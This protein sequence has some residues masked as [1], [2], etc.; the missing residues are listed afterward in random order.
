MKNGILLLALAASA[1]SLHAQKTPEAKLTEVA[2]F[3][4]QQV[5]GVGVSPRTGRAFVN[6][7]YWSDPQGLSVGEITES[8]TLRPY[9]DEAW[10]AKEGDPSKRF[11][12]V[13][14]VV[15]DD[16]EQLW[17]LDP[18]SPKMEGVV[19]GGP[20]LVQIDL[21]T[22]QVVWVIPFGPD[23]APAKSYLND[24]RID[25]K[26]G[27]AYLTESGEGSLVVVDLKSGKARRLLL[28][29]PSTAAEDT[30]LVVDGIRLVD[31]GTGATPRINADGI[32]LDLKNQCLYF[33]ALT[34]HTLYRVKLS[35]LNDESLP[36]AELAARVENLGRTPK[37]DGMLESPDGRVYL[38]A[39]EE[40]GVSVFDPATRT[41]SPVVRDSRLQWPDTLSAGPDGTIFVTTSQIHRMPKYHGGESRQKGPFGLYRIDFQ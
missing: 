12:C 1:L 19:P 18:A 25:S 2:L 4:S 17:V 36:P 40:N 14:S 5:T 41:V 37:P 28:G 11:V 22:N 7:P 6:F 23:I 8:G 32:A 27:K 26:A 39:I 20:K 10:N 31:P 29:D 9:P 13:Q 34:G 15:V 33:H 3:P 21:A 24:V 30:D 16:Q 38:T 35:D